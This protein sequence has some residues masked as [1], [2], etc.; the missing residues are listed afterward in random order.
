MIFDGMMLFLLKNIGDVDRQVTIRNEQ[1]TVSITL[2]RELNEIPIQLA[3]LI[4]RK[5]IHTT[6][7]L[8]EHA[9]MKIS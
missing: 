4:F 2:T 5:V 6:H 8:R 1:V 9:H 3:N 7:T